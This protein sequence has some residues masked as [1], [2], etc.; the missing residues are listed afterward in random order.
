[1]HAQAAYDEL[2]RRSRELSTL[3]SCS[4]LLGWDEQTYMPPGGA[5]HRAAQLGVLAGM[6]HER[7][8]D[9]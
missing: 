5:E 1:M 2:I 4:S 3:A 7:A 8:T 6:H 9:P